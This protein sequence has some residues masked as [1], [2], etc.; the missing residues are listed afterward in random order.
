MRHSAWR[1]QAG[2]TDRQ[3]VGCYRAGRVDGRTTDRGN[4]TSPSVWGLL[5]L[6]GD[7]FSFLNCLS[8]SLNIA[9]EI[10]VKGKEMAS[11]G[12]GRKTIKY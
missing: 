1:R 4:I 7:L 12:G 9:R 8:E 6:V 2:V 11:R 3:V 10:P 5:G